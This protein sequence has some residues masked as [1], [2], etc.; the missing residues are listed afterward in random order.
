MSMDSAID[1]F[2]SVALPDEILCSVGSRKFPPEFV[3]SMH[4]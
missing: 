3:R 1:T 2:T 4:Y